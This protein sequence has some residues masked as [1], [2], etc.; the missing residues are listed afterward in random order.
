MY[1]INVNQ[2]KTQAKQIKEKQM[3]ILSRNEYEAKE[4]NA[5]QKNIRNTETAIANGMTEEQAEAV[6]W[7][8]AKRHWMHT[9]DG[10]DLA[11]SEA[12]ANSELTGFI[13]QNYNGDGDDE[14]AVCSAIL[15]EQPFI[16]CE[17]SELPAYEDWDYVLDDDDREEYNGDYVAFRDAMDAKA[18]E[19][20]N[21]INNQIEN[22]LRK[23]DEKFGTSFCP[24]GASRIF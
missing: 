11:N 1:F 7:M 14:F 21:N 10:S 15:N 22:W 13:C 4:R 16:P 9:H 3:S 24:T 18:G 8:C 23:I 12:S 2:N 20:I 17:A 5:A 6:A 19:M